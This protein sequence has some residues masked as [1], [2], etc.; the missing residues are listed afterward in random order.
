MLSLHNDSKRKRKAPE[1]DLESEKENKLQ[2]LN[3]PETD[4]DQKP[5][6]KWISEENIETFKK[7]FQE[8]NLFEVKLIFLPRTCTPQLD[9]NLLIANLNDVLYAVKKEKL[10]PSK[11]EERNI[12]LAQNLDSGELCIFKTSEKIAPNNQEAIDSAQKEIN[13]LSKVGVHI[14]SLNNVAHD[15][16]YYSVERFCGNSLDQLLLNKMTLSEKIEIMIKS[17]KALLAFHSLK[18]LHRDI[19][20]ENIL[21]DKETGNVTFCDFELSLECDENLSAMTPDFYFSPGKIPPELSSVN[22]NTHKGYQYTHKTDIYL[23]GLTLKEL[24]SLSE[25]SL[26]PN[27]FTHTLSSEE[28]ETLNKVNLIL[29]KMVAKEP[30]ERADLANVL[31]DLENLNHAIETKEQVFSIV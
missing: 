4:L 28:V 5:R 14:T 18:L 26:Q 20:F 15:G 2:K 22:I 17:V 6:R 13:M 3:H 23:L 24:L 8:L 1:E 25:R 12:R 16:C 27:L 31:N 10:N 7:A 9:N 19:K 29:D 11:G 30:A 21:F